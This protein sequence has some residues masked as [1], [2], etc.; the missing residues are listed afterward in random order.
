MG[1]GREQRRGASDLE[2]RTLD[3]KR[4]FGQLQAKSQ[5]QR[6][7]AKRNPVAQIKPPGFPNLMISHVYP[8]VFSN[9]VA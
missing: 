2:Q 7:H 3:L 9:S 6:Q 4:K 8:A 5:Q 1:D